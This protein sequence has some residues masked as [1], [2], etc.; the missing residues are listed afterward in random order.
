LIIPSP[1]ISH[2]SRT[3]AAAVKAPKFHIFDPMVS[4]F[5][6]VVDKKKNYL[7]VLF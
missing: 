1:S 3:A 5:N 2:I 4:F 7:N 6:K